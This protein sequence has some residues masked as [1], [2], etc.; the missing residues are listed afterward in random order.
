MNCFRP[1]KIIKFFWL[2]ALLSS[3]K[4]YSQNY[5]T[6]YTD[7]LKKGPHLELRKNVDSLLVLCRENNDSYYYGKIAFDYSAKIYKKDLS[8]ALKYVEAS[9]SEFE[10]ANFYP[11]EY[12]RGLFRIG[13]FNY[14]NSEYDKAIYYYNKLINRSKNKYKI[15]RAYIEIGKCYDKKNNLYKSVTYF[16]KG[17]LL[18]KKENQNKSLI[19][20]YINLAKTYRNIGDLKN[21]ELVLKKADSI[22]ESI[23]TSSK[24]KLALNNSL[25]NLY[26]IK[27]TYN[28][29]EAKEYYFKNL[30]LAAKEKD[31]EAL[32]LTYNNLSYLYN[33][34]KNDSTKYFI[35][36]GLKL[37]PAKLMKARFHDNYSDFYLL[38]NNLKKA[39]SYI[40]DAL[41]IN[42]EFDIEKNQELSIL[43][44]THNKDYTLY[45]L[46]RKTEILIKLY[47]KEKKKH[48]LIKALKTIEYADNLVDIIHEGIN[49]VNAKLFWRKEASKTYLKGAYISFLLKKN[50]TFFYYTEKNKAILL[51]E[52]IV[53]NTERTNL[54]KNILEKEK[55]LNK[56]VLEL[57]NKVYQNI[58]SSIV[59]VLQDS[60]FNAK[61]TYEKYY[62]FIKSKYPKFFRK[63]NQTALMNLSSVQ[64]KLDKNTIAF[65]YIWNK[66]DDEEILL[67]IV[68]TNN[69]SDIFQVTNIKTLKINLKKYK[70]LIWKPIETNTLKKEFQKTSFLLFN[71]LFPLEKNRSLFKNKHTIIIPDGDLQNIPFESLIVN[72]K[73]SDYLL[74]Q[75][76]ISYA[77]SF[78]FSKNNDAVKR[79]TSGNLIGYSPKKIFDNKLPKLTYGEQEVKS[80]KKIVSGNIYDETATKNHFLEKSNNAKIIHLATHANADQSP[81]IAFSDDKLNLHELYTYKNNADLVVLSAC[82]TSIGKIEQG[83]GAYSLARGFFY[84]GAKS[85]VSSLWSVNDKSTSYI[86]TRFYKNLNSG[87][88]KSVALTNA[89]REYLKMHSLATVSPYYWASFVLIGNSDT[90]QFSNYNCFYVGFLVLFIAFVIFLIKKKK[91]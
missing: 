17:A 13:K 32:L 21:G 42:L 53:K 16:K 85:V 3:F 79:K 12:Y 6:K 29:K 35:E 33:T 4:A 86:M 37:N 34:K 78:S 8:L 23:K 60:L 30:K 66:N 1:K 59:N 38:K 72:E 22:S 28:F 74:Y 39:L 57:E 80:I 54:P 89:K 84:S 46:N 88:N 24:V 65:S 31:N 43:K 11:T 50:K 63:K 36:K 82:N 18:L 7:I 9:L 64:K 14:F 77:Y 19:G 41:K 73:T 67:G 47:K 68:I 15:A 69:S 45:C 40:D 71:Q 87:Q 91:K 75:T 27:G 20:L 58:N 76:D 48:Y 26:S 56:I 49:E 62:N 83:E 70:K 81:W 2:F 52:S 44:N 61:I 51:T 25:G 90:I 5:F 10:S 55:E